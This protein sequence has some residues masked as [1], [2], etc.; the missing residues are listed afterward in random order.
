MIVGGFL[1]IGFMILSV[2]IMVARNT[3]VGINDIIL[4]GLVAI[5]CLISAV[6]IYCVGRVQRQG[7]A[8]RLWD[9]FRSWWA[10]MTKRK[11]TIQTTSKMTI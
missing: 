3:V 2:A 11:M 6:S 8:P 1:L 4:L 7:K 10:L 5:G 9:R